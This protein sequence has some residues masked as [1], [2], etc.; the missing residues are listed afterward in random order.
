MNPVRVPGGAMTETEIA[1]VIC[2]E[3]PSS[4][5]AGI[6]ELTQLAGYRLVDSGTIDIHDYYYDTPDRRLSQGG[7]GLRLRELE[8]N[9]LLTLKGPA[10]ELA[11]GALERLEIEESWSRRSLTRVLQ[12][13][14]RRSIHLPQPTFPEPGI[15]PS[16]VLDTMGLETVQHRRNQRSVRMVRSTES[17]GGGPLA[18]LVIDQ[19]TYY[20]KIGQVQHHEVEIEAK[21]EGGLEVLQ[22]VA[23]NRVG[24]IATGNLVHCPVH[25]PASGYVIQGRRRNGNGQY[26]C[27]HSGNKFYRRGGKAC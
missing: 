20:L 18:E 22:E 25:Y 6:A 2:S 19:V 7:M 5:A 13:L 9:T 15:S 27:S 21:G 14:G 23:G 26:G 16:E 8:S 11:G 3:D 17:K 1:L 12:E 24:P 4:V 10:K